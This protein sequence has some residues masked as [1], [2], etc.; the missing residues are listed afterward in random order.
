MKRLKWVE[1]KNHAGFYG[2][3]LDERI[4]LLELTLYLM[5]LSPNHSAS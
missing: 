1:E 4:I 2:L 5:L 3:L